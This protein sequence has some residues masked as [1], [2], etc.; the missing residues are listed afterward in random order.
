MARGQLGPTM[1]VFLSLRQSSHQTSYRFSLHKQSSIRWSHVLCRHLCIHWRASMSTYMQYRH[2]YNTF[3][4]TQWTRTLIWSMC[5][6]TYSQWIDHNNVIHGANLTASRATL[7]LSLMTH[8][9]EAYNNSLWQPYF[10][11]P[12]LHSASVYQ[13]GPQVRIYEYEVWNV[14]LC[15]CLQ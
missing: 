12:T 13:H 4:P 10:M 11:L 14:T 2:P 5:E 7:W 8:I 15:W 9:A 3:K 6:Y 1:A